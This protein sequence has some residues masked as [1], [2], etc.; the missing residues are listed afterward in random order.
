MIERQT[1]PIFMPYLFDNKNAWERSI[2][3]PRWR[4]DM[5]FYEFMI[6]YQSYRTGITQEIPYNIQI[7]APR[8]DENPILSQSEIDALLASIKK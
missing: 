2:S 4:Y 3:D 8:Y 1:R 5:P 6:L 7:H